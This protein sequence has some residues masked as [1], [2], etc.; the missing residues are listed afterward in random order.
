MK[1][2]NITRGI[3]K[4]FAE[5]FINCAL[6]SLY[7]RHRDDLIIGVRNHYL[8]LY[9][10]C[11]SIA[12][13]EYT[14][15]HITCKIDKYYP[16]GHH[17]KGKDKMQKMDPADVCANYE[18]I[19]ANSLR[20]STDEK[21]AQSKLY[22]LNNNNPDSR[23]YCFDVEWKKAFENQQKKIDAQ[24][25]GRFDIMAISKEKPH[26]VAIIE[27]KYGSTAIGGKSGIYKHIED[28][29][30]YQHRNYF[31]KLEVCDIIESQNMLGID[32]PDLAMK[33]K[34]KDIQD[35]KFYVITLN[36]NVVKRNGSTPKQTMSGYLFSD[37]R[38]NCK[39]FSKKIVQTNFGDV[40]DIN[41]TIHVKFL[42]S[43]QTLDN[44]TI[45]DIIEHS[46]YDRE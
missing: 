29:N 24:F 19:K 38:W 6:F 33:L 21:K 13:I 14:K 25:N 2:K 45:N 26:E 4:E 39:R 34:A 22:L 11:D 18:T 31:D 10:N 12:K 23:W 44:L 41:N 28:F 9:Y 35:Y 46:G 37:R 42:F 27:L 43:D 30:K 20:K 16:E 40:A 7:Q 1:P 5:A 36:N 8:S 3:S 15:G 32:I 17:Y